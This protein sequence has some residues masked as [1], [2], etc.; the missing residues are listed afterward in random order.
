MTF[1]NG[2]FGAIGLIP[3]FRKNFA[4]GFCSLIT[5]TR[6]KK[7]FHYAITQKESGKLRITPQQKGLITPLRQPITP[8]PPCKGSAMLKQSD[9]VNMRSYVWLHPWIGSFLSRSV[10]INVLNDW[11]FIRAYALMKG[12]WSGKKWS[13]TFNVFMKVTH[14]STAPMWHIL[15][16]F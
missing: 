6:T 7:H 12:N 16:K 14:F 9:F 1:L 10:L 8:P 4:L 5:P 11:G 13:G 2:V 3:Q 15:W